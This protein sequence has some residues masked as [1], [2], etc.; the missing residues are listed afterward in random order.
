MHWLTTW[1]YVG[2][3]VKEL[4]DSIQ[5]YRG[6]PQVVLGAA[7]LGMLGHFGFLASFYFCALSLHQ[8]QVI[9]GFVDH[10]VGLPLPEALSAFIPTPAGIGALENAVAWFYKQFQL[11]IDPAS[12]K[13]QTALAFSNGLLTALGYRLTTLVWGGIGIFYY[14]TSRGEIRTAVQEADQEPKDKAACAARRV[15]FVGY[16]LAYLNRK[17]SF[18]RERNAEDVM[19]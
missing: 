3:I 2:R 8:G 4:M 7:L 1:K 11:S 14:L 19:R 15:L 12:T 9:P 16:A 13:E 5:L 18:L 10:V 6:K 17:G